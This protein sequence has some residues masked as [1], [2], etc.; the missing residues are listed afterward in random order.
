MNIGALHETWYV[1]CPYP[2]FESLVKY[3]SIHPSASWFA[4]LEE[5]E[6]E[7]NTRNF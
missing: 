6:K 2:F 3:C 1:G 7:W 4:S 5:A